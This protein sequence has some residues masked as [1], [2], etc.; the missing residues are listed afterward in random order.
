MP[1]L[2]KN[3]KLHEK[4]KKKEKGERRKKKEE[5][6]KEKGKRGTK[7]QQGSSEACYISNPKWHLVTLNSPSF[8]LIALIRLK[9]TKTKEH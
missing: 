4:Y 9:K 1:N 7:E 2:Y 3:T 8:P 6:K 5:R